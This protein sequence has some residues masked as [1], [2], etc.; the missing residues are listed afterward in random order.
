MLKRLSQLAAI[1]SFFSVF[2]SLASAQN[3]ASIPNLDVNR[4]PGVWYEIARYPFK[5]EKACKHDAVELVALAD[6]AHQ[7]QLID[8]CTTAKGYAQTRNLIAKQAKK[9]TAAEF[10]ITTIWP[11]HRKYWVLALDP[12]NRWSLIGSPNHRDLWIFSKTPSLDPDVLTQ[13]ETTA[14]AAG[15][16]ANRLALT[17]QKPLPA[18]QTISQ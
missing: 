3:A 4:L 16:P 11:F 10:K 2:P 5:P 17:P 18:P 7:L 15:F 6:K 8:S 14:A 9:S 13:I 1:V 12:A